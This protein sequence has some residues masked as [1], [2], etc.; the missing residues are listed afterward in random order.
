MIF[1]ARNLRLAAHHVL[2]YEVFR[3]EETLRLIDGCTKGEPVHALRE[4]Y[5][6]LGNAGLHQPV[7]D[8][9]NI[10]FAR[11]ECQPCAWGRAVIER[12]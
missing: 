4:L 1:M 7:S 9:I 2:K 11:D 3:F 5:P 12:C 8:G 10:V 6:I